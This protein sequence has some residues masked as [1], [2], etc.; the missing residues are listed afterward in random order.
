[1]LQHAVSFIVVVATIT[2]SIIITVI[3]IIIIPVLIYLCICLFACLFT[4]LFVIFVY[5]CPG[6]RQWSSSQPCHIHLWGRADSMAEVA[7]QPWSWAMSQVKSESLVKVM[8]TWYQQSKA[9]LLA[10]MPA[11]WHIS[12]SASPG[13]R[14][15]NSLVQ[16]MQE[17]LGLI[18]DT[19]QEYKEHAARVQPPWLVVV[20]TWVCIS[21]LQLSKWFTFK[22]VTFKSGL[23][24]FHFIH[25]GL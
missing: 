24:S 14:I 11:V 8:S 22:R 23:W 3:I 25:T 13:H 17:V 19:L 21:L 2:T 1:M 6:W 5:V 18:Q 10:D 7:G 16:T 9:L 20:L 12:K 15:D 4:C